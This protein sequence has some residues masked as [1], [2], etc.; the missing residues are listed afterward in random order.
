MAYFFFSL[1]ECLHISWKFHVPITALPLSFQVAHDLH[2][3]PLEYNFPF[4]KKL[5][6][7][8]VA[9]EHKTRND[10]FFFFFQVIG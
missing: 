2:L 9:G 10:L 4:W 6:S 1:R 7:E 8:R 5:T 3:N